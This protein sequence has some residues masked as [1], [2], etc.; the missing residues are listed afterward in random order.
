[1]IPK[2]YYYF[3]SDSAT[4]ELATS[5]RNYG[6]AVIQKFVSGQK[7][8]ALREESLSILKTS[9]N[10]HRL[11]DC[12]V[13]KLSVDKVNNIIDGT[14][15]KEETS[16]IKDVF[17][18][19]LVKDL[20]ADFFGNN[21]HHMGEIFIHHDKIRND[22]TNEWHFD[23]Y[24]PALKFFIYLTNTTSENGAFNFNIGSHREGHFRQMLQNYQGVFPWDKIPNF[25]PETE[26][27]NPT[28]IEA[29]EG[30][31]IIFNTN[32]IHRGGVLGKNKERLV[33]RGHMMYQPTLL[34]KVID[35][36]LR[37]PLNIAKYCVH[38][39]SKINFKHSSENYSVPNQK[40]DKTFE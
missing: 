18:R 16:T 23:K 17:N 30:S 35:Y 22:Y 34:D 19:N 26:V 2:E 12:E 24:A 3:D 6:I 38:S 25:I 14:S 31:L 37:S 4:S 33:I 32:G 5:I 21:P 36:L 29:G 40:Q 15:I 7:L 27:L 20:S 28:S 10:M 39:S 9:L 8:N 1:M 11:G 13:V